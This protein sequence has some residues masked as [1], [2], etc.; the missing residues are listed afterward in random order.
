[1]I[2]YTIT[3][4]E[5][6]D[7]LLNAKPFKPKPMKA[8]YRNVYAPN[9]RH[10]RKK[11]QWRGRIVINGVTYDGYYKTEKEA[12]IAIDKLLIKHG[13]SPVNILKKNE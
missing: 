3:G 9:P 1:M 2:T 5:L 8:R 10:Y 4:Y 13:K 7:Y 11:D 6:F 12:A